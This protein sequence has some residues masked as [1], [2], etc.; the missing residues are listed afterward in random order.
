MNMRTRIAKRL[1]DKM[2]ENAPPPKRYWDTAPLVIRAQMLEYADAVLDDLQDFLRCKEID[3]TATLEELR[4]VD[5]ITDA[6]PEK[7]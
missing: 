4:L 6:Y 2:A 5:A 1:H 7:E 3:G